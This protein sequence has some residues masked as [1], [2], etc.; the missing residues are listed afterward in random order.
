[1]AYAE[2]F[3]TFATLV[4]R[5]DLEVDENSRK[6]LMLVR[7]FGTPYPDQGCLSVPAKVVASLD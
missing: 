7:D 5:F 4:R 3:M 2:L 1:M 6:S